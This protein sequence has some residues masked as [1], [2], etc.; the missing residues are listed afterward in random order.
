M[1]PEITVSFYS[2]YGTN[3]GNDVEAAHATDAAEAEERLRR[4][5]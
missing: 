1:V 4:F 5:K 2:I 3:H